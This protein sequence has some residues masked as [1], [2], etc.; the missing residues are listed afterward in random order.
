[1][2]LTPEQFAETAD[3]LIEQAGTIVA[4]QFPPQSPGLAPAVAARPT[5]VGEKHNTLV[6]LQRALGETADACDL[7][8]H[9]VVATKLREH[10]ARI[11]LLLTTF[12]T[13]E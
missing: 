9:Q 13:G 3:E 6:G 1:M 2:A 5:T 12:T 4:G 7:A 10:C 11:E 8:G